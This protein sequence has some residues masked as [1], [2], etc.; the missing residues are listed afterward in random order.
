M[1]NRTLS[2][3]FWMSL[4]TGANVL[5][6]LGVLVILARLLTPGDFGLAAAALMVIGCSAVFAEFGIGPAVVQRPELRPAHLGTAF[7]L[8]LL[9]GGLLAGAIWFSASAVAGFFRLDEL[10][11]ILRVLA[12]VFPVQS[13]SVVSDSLLQRELRFRCLAVL[14]TIAV[15][16]G[17]GVVGV[18]MALHGFAAWS[19]VGAH[20]AQTGLKTVLLLVMRPHP[21][22]PLL[23]R[24]AC[25]E[26]LSFGG[27]FTASRLSNYLAGQGEHLVIGRCLGAVALGV[28]G[29]AYQLMAGPAV[30]FG[31]VLD[32][33]LFPTMVHVQDQPKRLAEAY[34]RGTALIALVI[35]PVSALVVAL[36]P[37]VVRIL[38]GREWDAVILPLQILGVGMLF[39]TGCKISDSLVR[40][41]GAVYRRTWRQTAYAAAVVVGAW[42]GH[43]WGVEGVSFAILVTLAV[44][45]F[46]MAEL[47]LR[48]ASMSWRTFAAAHVHGF[49]LAALVGVP[50]AL[51][52][53][54]LRSWQMSP[55]L[56]LVL[57]LLTVPPAVLIAACLP[58]LF[59]GADGRWM[60]R[61]LRGFLLGHPGQAKSEASAVAVESG[62]EGEP[63]RLLTR[64]LASAGVRYC[65]WKT[66]PDLDRI[67]SG[68]GDLD[69]LVERNNA[70]AFLRVVEGL[71]FKRAVGCFGA[72]NEQEQHLY[73]LDPRTGALLH[74]HVNFTLLGAGH[75]LRDME[76]SLGELVLRQ[77]A[78]TETPGVLAGLPVVTPA[79]AL[80]VF[81]LR[82]TEQYG[83]WRSCVAH[84]RHRQRL[85]A[86]MQAL[87]KADVAEGWRPLLEQWLPSLSHEL[88]AE[89]LTALEQPTGWWRRFRLA[90]RVR[91]QL[92]SPTRQQ[93]SESHSLARRAG[94]PVPGGFLR[95]LWWRL[96][97]GRGSPKQLPAGGSVIAVIGP[98][99]SGKSTM[100]ADT[101]QW[102]GKVFR[103]RAAHLGKPPSTWLTF[104]P[105][106]FWGLLR[107]LMP[108]LRPCRRQAEYAN[109]K[110]DNHQGLIARLRA[111]LLAY[112]RRALAKRLACLAADGWLIVCDRYPSA[113]VGAADSARLAQDDPNRGWLKG[114][115]ARLENRLYR[116]VPGP[117][118]VVRLTTPVHL[119]VN[120]NR[121]RDKPDKESEEYVRRRHTAFRPPVF[122]K[123][124]TIE[125]D[126]NGPRT[127]TVQRLR[128][129]L[130]EL[131]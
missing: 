28:Y 67:L 9:L 26:L 85:Q 13:L 94:E 20:L 35:L 11:P 66:S 64:A 68:R 59:L 42:I 78:P 47:A 60:L 105:N 10:T 74:L 91:R 88:F 110:T 112:D 50:V 8:L 49:S 1:T 114:L 22:W 121:D 36:A 15:V 92:T 19:L 79:A 57:A 128:Q 45:F 6:L 40:A 33:V 48:L 82:T 118:I 86:K 69:L 25:A 72:A 43:P 101:A 84:F 4:A 23:E 65:C 87:L 54:V 126:T 81:V 122:T 61:K 96:F 73:G 41:T 39:R 58:E 3:L 104:L 55:L 116:D 98:D 5:S 2:G 90:R 124:R 131:L 14:E 71:G 21:V 97:H 113:D 102:L 17:Y 18:V 38:L 24:R 109:G 16:L 12:L 53:E 115:L 111:V 30:L 103:V 51:T 125:L 99:A 32:R 127:E 117:D 106:L 63:L 95:R 7:T 107:R 83:R 123:A 37:E 31:N 130:W 27:G 34:R 93:G 46:L 108:R 76:P 100:V 129:R 120:R 80:I 56:I 77:S 70:D 44:N 75:P 62:E 119:A 89:C 29:R 52:A